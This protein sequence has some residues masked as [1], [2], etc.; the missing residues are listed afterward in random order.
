[1]TQFLILWSAS[2]ITNN[3]PYFCPTKFIFLAILFTSSLKYIKNL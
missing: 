3:F 2:L 1:V